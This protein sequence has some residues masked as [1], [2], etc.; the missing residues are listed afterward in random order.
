MAVRGG[1]AVAWQVLEH[2]QHATLHQAFGDRRANRRDF[3]RRGSIGAIADDFV[4]LAHRHIGEREAVD[5]DAERR[6][7]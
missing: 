5:R 3:L 6:E 1:A 4:R 2:W 7:I